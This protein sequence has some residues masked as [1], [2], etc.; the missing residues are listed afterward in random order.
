[1]PHVGLPH[2]HLPHIHLPD[3]VV[4]RLRHKR[5]DRTGEGP[6]DTGTPAPT[7]TPTRE[8]EPPR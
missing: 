2:L 4:V 5:D 1:V 8:L 7:P 6:D 3:R